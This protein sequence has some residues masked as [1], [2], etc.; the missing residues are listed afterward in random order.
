MTTMGPLGERYEVGEGAGP[1]AGHRYRASLQTGGAMNPGGF[2]VTSLGLLLAF[3]G[4]ASAQERKAPPLDALTRS[5]TK[6]PGSTWG[7]T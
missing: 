6:A 4:T 2:A 7:P 3:A 1:P 5:T